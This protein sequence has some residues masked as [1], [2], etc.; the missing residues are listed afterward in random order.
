MSTVYTLPKGI[1][2]LRYYNFTQQSLFFE[3]N[4]YIEIEGENYNKKN[5]ALEKVAKMPRYQS[6]SRLSADNINT[7]TRHYS[8]NNDGKMVGGRIPFKPKDTLFRN[9]I[10]FA[11][12]T[13]I[14]ASD[15]AGN[16]NVVLYQY[17]NGEI[18]NSKVI[19]NGL[20]K[21]SFVKVD[22]GSFIIVRNGSAFHKFDTD[23]NDPVDTIYA[24]QFLGPG[25]IQDRNKPPQV[26]TSA[27]GFYIDRAF[28]ERYITVASFNSTS[29]A[30]SFTSTATPNYILKYTDS[31]VLFDKSLNIIKEVFFTGGEIINAV[32]KNDNEI[33]FITQEFK[34]ASGVV[35]TTLNAISVSN[36]LVVSYLFTDITRQTVAT[37][38]SPDRIRSFMAQIPTFDLDE[39]T[40]YYSIMK[41]SLSVKFIKY[42]L[43]KI[44]Q[45]DA[46]KE[47]TVSN[48]IPDILNIY[49]HDEFLNNFKM[50]LNYLKINNRKFLTFTTVTSNL[51]RH[52][53]EDYNYVSPSSTSSYANIKSGATNISTF[54][55]LYATTEFPMYLFEIVDDAIIYRDSLSI[56][57]IQTEGIRAIFP[58]GS[59]FLLI[60]RDSLL[61]LYTVDLSTNKFS[62]SINYTNNEVKSLGIDDNERLWYI[63]NTN[64]YNLE[65]V[66]P[67][68]ALDIT[69]KFSDTSLIY[70]GNDINTNIIVDSKNLAGER[71]ATE[72]KLFLEGNAIFRNTQSKSITLTTSDTQALSVPIVI[73]GSGSINV[74]PVYGE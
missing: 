64:N 53:A 10:K 49:K 61:Q 63:E 25:N 55:R 67:Y 48:T 24:G 23:T 62:L 9:N 26:S 33:I 22:E 34:I 13:E 57:N 69:V 3:A 43:N 50:S 35:T 1:K 28:Y 51:T 41:D 17:K 37:P 11:D 38:E 36:T 46:K 72:I 59:E 27:P 65:M 74:T 44:G 71:K 2:N 52:Y 58:M 54:A 31:I 39:G 47:L 8:I 68:L 6:A 14:V 73:V 21:V 40:M 16:G 15:Q 19:S 5:I 32:K 66:S 18:L 30:L 29:G 7:I 56:R 20:G 60:V 42:D 70:Q 4:D 45:S 12:G